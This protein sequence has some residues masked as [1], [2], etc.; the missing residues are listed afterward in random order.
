MPLL[1]LWLEYSQ[2]QVPNEQLIVMCD[3]LSFLTTSGLVWKGTACW[4]RE[5]IRKPSAVWWWLSHTLFKQPDHQF[6]VCSRTVQVSRW[7]KTIPASWFLS[8]LPQKYYDNLWSWVLKLPE[9]P[10]SFNMW[11]YNIAGRPTFY[12]FLFLWNSES[13]SKM[14]LLIGWW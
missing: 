3:H 9:I 10:V 2:W 7:L 4:A 14:A 13:K 5:A 1:A 11:N 8:L 12:L 6:E